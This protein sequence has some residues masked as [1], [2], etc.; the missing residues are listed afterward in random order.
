[1]FLIYDQPI[2]TGGCDCLGHN[3]GGDGADVSTQRLFALVDAF[4][5][6]DHDRAPS[7][8]EVL[9]MLDHLRFRQGEDIIKAQPRI[10]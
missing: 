1:M 5:H 8:A 4:L 2:G 3:G 6:A 10:G 7:T 9:A